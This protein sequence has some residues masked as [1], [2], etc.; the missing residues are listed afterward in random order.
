[1]HFPFNIPENILNALRKNRGSTQRYCKSERLKDL[2]YN[3]EHLPSVINPTWR[4][5]RDYEGV[6]RILTAENSHFTSNIVR[7]MESTVELV[8]EQ[9]IG[10][11]DSII[12][13]GAGLNNH[14]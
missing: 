7:R 13:L 6:K 1:M 10:V 9:R 12:F 11:R 3:V 2:P 14:H 4:F 5:V 8:L